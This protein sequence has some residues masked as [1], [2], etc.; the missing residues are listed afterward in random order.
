MKTIIEV[1][2]ID[3]CFQCSRNC[4]G[5]VRTRVVECLDVELDTTVQQDLCDIN[6]KPTAIEDCN[7]YK[8]AS[9][10]TSPW[11]E[12]SFLYLTVYIY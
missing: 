2:F 1:S 4:G 9:W 11:S 3:W 7:Q 12:V 5:G 6:T 8:C 10:L